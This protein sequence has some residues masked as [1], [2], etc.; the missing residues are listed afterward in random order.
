MFAEFHAC[1][2]FEASAKVALLNAGNRSQGRPQAHGR[3]LSHGFASDE[4][5][6]TLKTL[7][8]KGRTL[9][10]TTTILL[11]LATSIS[12]QQATPTPGDESAIEA[13]ETAE[14]SA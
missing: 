2:R 8:R 14:T 12:A 5:S 7:I 6:P 1:N 3:F 11:S 13:S 9:A 4:S 10:F